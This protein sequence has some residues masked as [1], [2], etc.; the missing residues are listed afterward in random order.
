M[1]K[2]C[3]VI[4]SALRP[5][6]GLRC[7]GFLNFPVEKFVEDRGDKKRSG[8]YSQGIKG[9]GYDLAVPWEF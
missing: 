6:S 9:Q 5:A 4:Y 1:H 7:G 3:Q 2:V 8:D